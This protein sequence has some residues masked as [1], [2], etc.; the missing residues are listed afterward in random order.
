M[1]TQLAGND[2]GVKE[3]IESKINAVWGLVRHIP[4]KITIWATWWDFSSIGLGNER[5]R[6]RERESPDAGLPTGSEV[7]VCVA[8]ML[9]NPRR[10][11]WPPMEEK[12]Y[13]KLEWCAPFSPHD[14]V[15]SRRESSHRGCWGGVSDPEEEAIMQ[16]LGR[17]QLWCGPNCQTRLKETFHNH[18]YN[19]H[20]FS[21][22]FGTVFMKRI[23]QSSGGSFFFYFG[24]QL[25]HYYGT[26]LA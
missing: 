10:N 13:A 15:G 11:N 16:P 24:F 23:C 14:R 9:N 1:F 22:F 2:L 20:P 3:L 18:H 5:E 21:W 17:Q 19:W 25:F 7:I 12:G 4:Q 26:A 8:F 6:Y